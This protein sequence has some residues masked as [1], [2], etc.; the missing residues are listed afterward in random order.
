MSS[1]AACL[2]ANNR[3]CQLHQRVFCTFAA[4][5]AAGSATSASGNR[6]S[7]AAGLRGGSASAVA[8]RQQPQQPVASVCNATTKNESAAAVAW[9]RHKEY[10]PRRSVAEAKARAAAASGAITVSDKDTSKLSASEDFVDDGDVFIGGGSP[11]NGPAY[12]LATATGGGSTNGGVMA[13]HCDRGI[14]ERDAS[15]AHIAK[16]SSELRKDLEILAQSE[17]SCIAFAL[18]AP[19][20]WT[21]WSPSLVQ[22]LFWRGRSVTDHVSGME[23]CNFVH[24]V[25]A[26]VRLRRDRR[27]SSSNPK[28]SLGVPDCASQSR[29]VRQSSTW[30]LGHRLTQSF[31]FQSSLFFNN[32]CSS[33]DSPHLCLFPGGF[34]LLSNFCRSFLSDLTASSRASSP[35]SHGWIG[36]P[37]FVDRESTLCVRATMDRMGDSHLAGT[38]DVVLREVEARQAA[39][40]Q[41]PK[42]RLELP[43]SLGSAHL[44]GSN[45]TAQHESHCDWLMLLLPFIRFVFGSSWS[46][47]LS[48]PMIAISLKF[49]AIQRNRGGHD[50]GTASLALNLLETRCQFY[51]RINKF[52][53]L[54]FCNWWVWCE[55]TRANGLSLGSSRALAHDSAVFILMGWENIFEFSVEMN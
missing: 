51:A 46:A 25:M 48:S 50:F 27:Y 3:S 36:I 54:P 9:Q 29:L 30:S 28:E 37:E 34:E 41:S 42:R 49:S 43:Q 18:S 15:D 39:L 7:L 13:E 38:A 55:R 17:V 24:S 20:H 32:G 33:L 2:A 1:R 10:D 21:G 8:G 16:M 35:P 52:R 53:K 6:R 26:E 22:F 44:S 31:S 23:L 5:V 4:A 45:T 11:S 19:F 40:A 12:S 47:T 14:L